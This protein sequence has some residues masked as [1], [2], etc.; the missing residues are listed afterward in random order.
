VG[1]PL[2]P[3]YDAVAWVLKQIYGFLSPIFGQSSGWTWALSIVILVVLMRLIMVPLFVK[4]MHTTRA[5]SALAPQMQ[6]LRKKY[7]NDKQTLQQETMKLYQQ[8]G[9]NPLMGCLP[10]VLQLPMFFALFSVL[11]AIAEW[12]V[13]QTPRYGLTYTMVSSAQKA[14]ILGATVSDK[15]LFPDGLHVPLQ[16]KAVILVAVLISMTTTYLTVRQ[17]MKRGMM[18]AATPDNPMGQS[19]KYMMYIM[20]FFALS[21]LYWPFGLV[22]YWVTT[23]CWTLGQQWVLFRTQPQLSAAGAAGAAGATATSPAVTPVVTTRPKRAV[24]GQPKPGSTGS[25]ARRDVK[26]DS[27]EGS[28]G[29]RGG[30]RG[31]GGAVAQ[32]NGAAKPS[33]GRRSPDGSAPGSAGRKA[34]A[35][36]GPAAKETGTSGPARQDAAPSAN[37]SGTG[38]GAGAVLRRLGKRAEPEPQPSAPEVKLVRQQRQRQSRSK[39]SGKR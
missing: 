32:S 20:P 26:K 12:K 28:G 8:A 15:F 35:T 36:R 18:P 30:G 34:A 17:S 29:G 3:I 39:R 11:K 7:K 22:L 9:V 6:A 24:A 33:A 23:N 25:P 37:G 4:Q 1:N 13:H 31:T 21:G 19:Q 16:A 5:M 10:V 14:K 38:G 27:E 2:N